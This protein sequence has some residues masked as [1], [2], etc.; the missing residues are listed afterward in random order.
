[1]DVQ[2]GVPLG[3]LV[4]NIVA[5]LILPPTSLLLIICSALWLGRRFFWAQCI[6]GAAVV[7]LAVVSM[8]ATGMLLARPF[9]RAYVPFD[10]MLLSPGAPNRYMVLVLGG[11]R[12][13]GAIE[14]AQRE[15]LSAASLERARYG[16]MLARTLAVPVAVSGGK[17]AGGYHSEAELMR[18]FI[19]DEMGQRVALVEDGSNDTLQNA[20]FTSAQ[21]RERGVTDV[22]LVTD[23]VHMP[24][25]V[26][27]FKPTALGIVPAPMRFYSEAPML[28]TDYLPSGEG[29]GKSQRALRELLGL[30]FYRLKGV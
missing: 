18:Q 6:G 1:L 19:E 25:A 22:V 13:L 12:E 10:K 9:E 5:G 16:A 29:L 14:H 30:M 3:W 28:V 8:P 15:R 21:L 11:G 26:R 7:L 20:Q 2:A 23:A 27:A 17:P 4:S 24:R